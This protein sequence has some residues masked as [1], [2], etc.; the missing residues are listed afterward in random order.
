LLN[1]IAHWLSDESNDKLNI[2]LNTS[3]WTREFPREGIVPHQ[4]LNGVDCGIFTIMYV[5][6]TWMM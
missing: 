2:P 1:N 4:Q 6:V 5:V 3:E